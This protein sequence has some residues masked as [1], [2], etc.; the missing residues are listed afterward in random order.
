MHDVARALDVDVEHR[1]GVAEAE[2][3]DAGCVVDDLAAAHRGGEGLE[4]EDVAANRLG[5]QLAE[6]A[7][8]VIGPGQG[9]DRPAVGEE[10]LDDRTA[11]EPRPAGD[12]DA[13]AQLEPSDRA[14]PKRARYSTAD[15]TVMTAAASIAH[16][17]RNSGPSGSS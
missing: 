16:S 14:D 13:F 7:R 9:L 15:S 3:V 4:V 17:S 11:E 6:G 12:E 10:P 8:R 1:R 2:R 5:A